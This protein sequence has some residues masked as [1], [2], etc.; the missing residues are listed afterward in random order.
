[1][2]DWFQVA[3]I[4]SWAFVVGLLFGVWLVERKP[5]S[6]AERTTEELHYFISEVIQQGRLDRKFA[7]MATTGRTEFRD[8]EGRLWN[9]TL[10]SNP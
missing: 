1:M 2:M 4:A 9:L 8:S 6:A 5:K 3:G 10:Q 7:A